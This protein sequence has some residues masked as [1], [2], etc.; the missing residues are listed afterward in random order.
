MGAVFKARQIS[1]DRIVA[2]KVL[3]PRIAKDRVF[4]ERFIREARVSAQLN[5]PHIVQGIEVGKDEASGLYYFAMEYIDG[6]TVRL[7]LKKEGALEERRALEIVHS[8]AQA[9]GCAQKAG[10]I[11]RDIKPDNILL[12]SRGEAR[13]ADL[14]L[15]KRV[16][17]AA[18]EVAAEGGDEGVLEGVLGTSVDAALTQA[19][20]AMGTPYYMSPEQ[21]QGQNDRID[22]RADLYALGA[23][24]FHMVTGQAPFARSTVTGKPITTS[25]EIMKARLNGPVPDAC[26]ANPKISAETGRLI[27]RLMQRNPAQRFQTP[28]ALLVEIEGLL[29]T[30]PETGTRP[31]GARPAIAGRKGSEKSITRGVR[32]E[33][34]ERGERAEARGQAGGRPESKSNALGYVAAGV[35]LAVLLGGGALLMGGKSS[36]GKSPAKPAQVV[37]AKNGAKS[38]SPSTPLLSAKPVETRKSAENL[39]AGG[40]SNQEAKTDPAETAK[41]QALEAQPAGP[42]VAS[43]KAERPEAVTEIKKEPRPAPEQPVEPKSAPAVAEPAAAAFDK[44]MADVEQ[45][46]STG[47]DQNAANLLEEARS[48]PELAS[49]AVELGRQREAVRWLKDVAQ[50]LETGARKL[51]EG[52]AFTFELADGTKLPVGQGSASKVAGFKDGQLE[53]DVAISEKGQQLSF[54]KKYKT[55][56]LTPACRRALALLSA[57]EDD[58]PAG[59]LKAKLAYL[60]LVKLAAGRPEAPKEEESTALLA[61]AKAEGAQEETL[62]T[63]QPWI[64]RAKRRQALE[65]AAAQ[66]VKAPSTAPLPKERKLYLGNGVSLDLVLIPAGEFVMGSKDGPMNPVDSSAE[67][68][69][70]EVPQ[71]RVKISRPFYLGKFEVTQRQ[72]AAVMGQNPSDYKGDDLPVTS[73]SWWAAVSF[74]EKVSGLTKA[75]LRLPSE[76]QWEYACL[77]GGEGPFR[78]WHEAKGDSGWLRKNLDSV[79]K[80]AWCLDNSRGRIHPVGQKEPNAWGLYDL[81]GNASEWCQDWSGPYPQGEALDPQGPAQ[82]TEKIARGGC[83]NAQFHACRPTVRTELSAREDARYLDCGFRVLLALNADGKPASSGETAEAKKPAAEQGPPEAS[84]PPEKSTAEVGAKAADAAGWTDLLAGEGLQGWQPF[85]GEW[86]REGSL[87]VCRAK[88]GMNILAWQKVFTDFEL[89]GTMEMPDENVGGGRNCAILVGVGEGKEISLMARYGFKTWTIETAISPAISTKVPAIP[90]GPLKI[91]VIH[92]KGHLELYHNDVKVVEHTYPTPIKGMVGVGGFFGAPGAQPRFGNLKIRSLAE[93]PAQE[94]MPEKALEPRPESPAVVEKPP[95]R[96]STPLQPLDKVLFETA[97]LLNSGDSKHAAAVLA[98]ALTKPE[99]AAGSAEIQAE[100]RRMAWLADLEKS[101]HAGAES[102]AAG[103]AFELAFKDGKKESVGGTSKQKVLSLKDGQLSVELKDQGVVLVRKYKLADLVEGTRR[104]LALLSVSEDPAA[105]AILQVKWAYRGLLQCAAQPQAARLAELEKGLSAA[106][107]KGAP[108]NLVEDL[109]PWLRRLHARIDAA[110]KAEAERLAEEQRKAEE[111]LN[112]DN[113]LR[114]AQVDDWALTKHYGNT[115]SKV[116]VVKKDLKSITLAIESRGGKAQERTISLTAPH[117]FKEWL[118]M[119]DEAKKTEEGEEVITVKGKSFKCKRE[120]YW[121]ARRNPKNKNLY[122]EV[123]HQIWHCPELPLA[124]MARYRLRW[125]ASHDPA[126]TFTG[127]FGQ[128]DDLSDW[129]FGGAGAAVQAPPA[130]P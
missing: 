7:L 75:S 53:L 54:R 114:K 84:K 15:A 93:T 98:E 51:V 18:E 46:L 65:A 3:P 69:K 66:S 83:A 58:K 73:M 77:A 82:G 106:R 16:T 121:D 1:L 30:L 123:E 4:V 29:K 48:K 89:T 109:Q 21:A 19:G 57:V 20:K 39:K 108:A 11:H 105:A 91:R 80:V 96:D 86:R 111:K 8:V 119:S 45:L 52:R 71:H 26:K 47:W 42:E 5:H 22:I 59:E 55:D 125:V 27:A 43:T 92:R 49:Y 112:A 63:V 56:A 107:A 41:A 120:F 62:A 126:H 33:R 23:T 78:P 124:G 61:Q 94:K 36:P 128:L 28:D 74:C 101:I 70:L 117:G 17:D 64:E 12:T 81:L 115:T 110:A 103:R 34:G 85:E 10:I 95:V 90:D 118:G 127:P 122:I 37:E 104:E 99:L 40:P 72:Y 87:I 97:A 13:L 129:G 25:N 88:T 130:V 116:S 76:A 44:L 24:L 31:A 14:G 2:L 67:V 38:A 9:L 6:P 79:G 100:Q 68:R 113:F 32:A 50:A 60:D 35:T 102:L